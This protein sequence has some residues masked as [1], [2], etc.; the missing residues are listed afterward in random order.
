MAGH[1]AGCLDVLALL[2]VCLEQSALDAGNMDI[3]YLLCLQE[4]PPA[5]IMSNRSLMSVGGR[6]RAFAPLSD[7]RWVTT[8]LAFLREQDLISQRRSDVATNRQPSGV[9]Q[10]GEEVGWRKKKAKAK[11]KAT[12]QKKTEA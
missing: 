4:E 6:H 1:T 11:A 12:W 3:G 8:S 9:D 10:D 2:C 5:A 7:Q